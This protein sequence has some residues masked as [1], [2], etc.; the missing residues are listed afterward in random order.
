MMHVTWIIMYTVEG[1]PHEWLQVFEGFDSM[2]TTI[3]KYHAQYPKRYIYR[4][5]REET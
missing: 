3:L 2:N 4:M 5:F 1:Q